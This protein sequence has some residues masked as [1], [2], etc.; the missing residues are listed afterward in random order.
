M[1]FDLHCHSNASDGKLSPREVLS[2]VASSDV[3]LFALTDHDTVQ[4]YTQIKDLDWP[5][6]LVSGIEL[7]TVWSGIS[8]HVIGL[9]FDPEHPAMLEAI[10]FLRNARAARA[11]VIDERLAK[12]GMPGTL[13]GALGFCPDLGQVGRPHFA[14]FM[15]Q[16]GYVQS[17][18]EAFDRWLGNGKLGDVKTGWPT[19]EQTIAWIKQAG[20]VAVLAHPL[21]Y[22]LTFSKM[23]RLVGTFR[24]YGGDAIEVLG[25]QAQPDQKRE[26][27]KLAKAEGL[28]GSGG[29]DFHNPEWAWAQIGRIEALPDDITPV[30]SLFKH[31][32]IVRQ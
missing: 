11:L 30:W 20:G 2:V 9:D 12:K 14:E 4:G 26:L 22:D 15:V 29:S 10:D 3:Q 19:L 23:R 32:K 7:S 27:I 24:Q 21:R 31:T 1:K 18:N 13:Q 6:I 28:A 5:F 17:I 16:Q 25:Q 8:V